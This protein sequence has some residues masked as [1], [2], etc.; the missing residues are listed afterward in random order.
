[1][2]YWI[3]FSQSS[4][5]NINQIEIISFKWIVELIKFSSFSIDNLIQI[6]VVIFKWII[7]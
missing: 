3:Q 7:E 5:G 1:M 4:H 6:K 2:K